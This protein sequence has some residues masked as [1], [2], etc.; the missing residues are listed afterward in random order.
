MTACEFC[1]AIFE[2]RSQGRPQRFCP[3][4]SCRRA[5][6]KEA[7]RIGARALRRQRRAK[8]STKKQFT[9]EG[10]AVLAL[11]RAARALRRFA[12]EQRDFDQAAARQDETGCIYLTKSL[13]GSLSDQ[14]RTEAPI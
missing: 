14:A 7:R 13:S 5:F 8:K 3:G 4:G 2:P 11:R 10:L 6:D 9:T 1:N 12:A